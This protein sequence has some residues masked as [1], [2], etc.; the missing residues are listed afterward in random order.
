M[1]ALFPVGG[2]TQVDRRSLNFMS[3][4]EMATHENCWNGTF[5]IVKVGVANLLVY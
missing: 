3:L 1:T 4:R 2:S 5:R